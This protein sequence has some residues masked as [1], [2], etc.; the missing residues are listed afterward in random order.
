MET[1]ILLKHNAKTYLS[2]VAIS[3]LTS[4]EHS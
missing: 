4:Y 1:G 3:L 2:I